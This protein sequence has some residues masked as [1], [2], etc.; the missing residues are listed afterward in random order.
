MPNLLADLPSAAGG[1]V[2][3][4]LLARGG[5][6]I[7]RIVSEGQSTPADQPY[8]QDHDE[9]VLLL[10]GAAGLWLDGE[11]ETTLK[12]GDHVLIPARRRH[13]VTWTEAGRPTVWLAVHVA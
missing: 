6:R 5:V 10:A 8:D 9:W 11:G 7:E 12:P 1:E 4:E 3:T 2:F 13:R